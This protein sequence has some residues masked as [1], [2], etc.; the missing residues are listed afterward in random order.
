[1]PL[2]YQ[3]WQIIDYNAQM[4]G[5]IHS[6]IC[7]SALYSC[8]VLFIGKSGAGPLLLLAVHSY[9]VQ[10][11]YAV[12][13]LCM[14]ECLSS[15]VNVCQAS[16]LIRKLDQSKLN[17]I[18]RVKNTGLQGNLIAITKLFLRLYIFKTAS[19]KILKLF[20]QLKANW[21]LDNRSINLHPCIAKYSIF[22]CGSFS[23]KLILRLQDLGLL[24]SWN[25]LYTD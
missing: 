16:W 20:K 15:N 7:V 1:M 11:L 13:E 10:C 8:L 12:C 14:Y 24:S 9:D 19:S 4:W 21:N 23:F 3:V 5:N 22:C 18:I 25:I 2:F 6:V 17:I